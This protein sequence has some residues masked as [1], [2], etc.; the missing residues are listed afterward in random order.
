MFKLGRF[1]F[2]FP[3]GDNPARIKYGHVLYFLRQNFDF[4]RAAVSISDRAVS[5]SRGLVLISDRFVI[6]NFVRIMHV[7]VFFLFSF[8]SEI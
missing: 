4:I 5:I 8:F 2:D 7:I 3:H 1:S 6:C